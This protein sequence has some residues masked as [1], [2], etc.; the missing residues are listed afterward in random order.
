MSPREI[1][2]L[3]DYLGPEL[4]GRIIADARHCL[5][6]SAVLS[7]SCLGGRWS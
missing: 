5:S 2:A 3:R 4:T 1:V 7:Q 6:L